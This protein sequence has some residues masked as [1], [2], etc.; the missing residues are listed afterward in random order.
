V[1]QVQDS[2]DTYITGLTLSTRTVYSQT[3]TPAVERHAGIIAK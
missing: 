3:T 1:I 2:D